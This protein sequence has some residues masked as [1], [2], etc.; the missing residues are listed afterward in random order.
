VEIFSVKNLSFTYPNAKNPVVNSLSLNVN[1]GDFLLLI[2]ESGCGKTTL[3]RLLKKELA[4]YGEKQGE[5]FF[6]GI[7]I[8]DLTLKNS[9]ENIGFI[10]QDPDSQIVTDKV[11]TEL[12]FGLENLGYSSTDIRL[13]VSEF[14]SYFGLSELFN[15]STASL[16]GGEKQLLNLASVMAMNP[17]VLILD[18]PTSQL[19]PISATE[20]INTLKR[21][22][23]DFGTTII[24]AEHHLQELFALAD[25]IAFM[26]KGKLIC[27]DTPENIA[28]LVKDRNIS[29]ALPAP[30][31]VFNSLSVVG[32]CPLTIRD[33]RNFLQKNFSNI[34]QEIPV[35]TS[36]SD[37]LAI[38]CKNIWFRYK[39]D[40]DD[41]L[42][43]C[44]L[45]IHSGELYAI[46]GENG[47]G[48]STLI[49]TLANVQKPYR[50]KINRF[51]NKVAYLPQNPKN[52]FVKDTLEED[53]KSVDNSYKEIISDFKLDNLLSQHPYDLSGGELQKSAIAKLI[54]TKPQIL[55]L[56]E[57]TK[58]LDAFA[59][60]ELGELFTKLIKDKMTI[61]MVTHDIEFAS[62]YA[63]RCGLLFDGNITAEN[64][65]NSFFT[66]N[67]FY[68]TSAV[69]M[70]RNILKSAV[71][72]SDIV[73]LCRGEL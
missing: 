53:L 27:C 20:F 32:D 38:S 30:V 3:L 63:T 21:L 51:N 37:E 41:V 44:D 48:K 66:N 19:D 10:M 60:E 50:G 59:K 2:G 54:L 68:T 57:P 13:R 22:N 34:S 47:S 35:H 64:F 23:R 45:K 62:E 56:D 65:T 39:K 7:K 55:L 40:S 43:N 69:K 16:S 8:D 58:G 29:K 36:V 67:N 17:Q 61:V 15:K 5:I 73:S 31:R 70:S 14:A 25:K 72:V 12:A 11:Y 28:Q 1:A 46:L 33:G 26:E 24:I 71:T 6:N 9:A 42:K 18:E 4:P 52:L 49:K